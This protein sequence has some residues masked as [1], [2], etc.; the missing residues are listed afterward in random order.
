M[1]RFLKSTSDIVPTPA[2]CKVEV[3][4]QRSQMTLG[5]SVLTTSR[6]V[7]GVA[8][9][10]TVGV[11]VGSVPVGVGVAVPHPMLLGRRRPHPF[12]VP[13]SNPLLSLTVRIQVPLGFCPLKA[14]SWSTGR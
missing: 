10:V 5:T 4:V 2:T 8:V 1:F 11:E 12:R 13:A 3:I 14:A 9:P 6:I 7:Q